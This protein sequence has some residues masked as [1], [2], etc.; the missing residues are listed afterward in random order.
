MERSFVDSV[1]LVIASG[2]VNSGTLLYPG[3]ADAESITLF[4]VV[5]GDATKTYK[6][7]ISPDKG[8]TWYDWHDGTANVSGPLPGIASTYSQPTATAMRVVAS[9]AVASITTF[10]VTKSV[11]N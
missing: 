10:K 4:S 11:V 8:A 2:Q 6:L 1:D 5:G 3:F 9:A 7:Q